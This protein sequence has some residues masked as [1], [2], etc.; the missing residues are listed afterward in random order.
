MSKH[1]SP[2]DGSHAPRRG[3]PPLGWRRWVPGDRGRVLGG[4]VRVEEERRTEER[5]VRLREAGLS[6]R[7]ICDALEA[8]GRRTKRGGRWAAQT[9]SRVLA[10][11]GRQ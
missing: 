9:V 7:Q 8:E 11:W 1:E 3:S 5:M 4:F 6:L 2:T 10:R